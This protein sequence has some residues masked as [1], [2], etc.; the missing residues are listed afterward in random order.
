MGCG[1]DATDA[2]SDVSA[3]LIMDDPEL[4]TRVNSARLARY[5]NKT[6]RLPCQI[7]SVNE[8]QILVEASDGGQVTVVVPSNMRNEHIQDKYIEVVGKVFDS[9]TVHMLAYI[10][11][12]AHLD[13]KLVND[14]TEL[15]HDPR[16]L[17]KMFS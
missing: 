5:T 14:T 13:M 1:C 8:G 2:G 11:L 9:A 16:F 15:I 17:Q 7:L 10:G 3:R 6:I 12:G 4:S